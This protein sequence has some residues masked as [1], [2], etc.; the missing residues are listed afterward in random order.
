M[1]LCFIL[2]CSFIRITYLKNPIFLL[3]NNIIFITLLTCLIYYHKLSN[4]SS[5]FYH[6]VK[7]CFTYISNRRYTVFN[8]KRTVKTHPVIGFYPLVGFVP[9]S[10]AARYFLRSRLSITSQ[11][12]Y[13]GSLISI[14]VEISTGNFN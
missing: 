6:I 13:T 4:L 9:L 8:I 1:C 3:Y 10:L 7:L 5:I 11:N 14:I 2:C 12:V